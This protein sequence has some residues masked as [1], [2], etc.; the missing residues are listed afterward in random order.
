MKRITI[1]LSDQ[2][3]VRLMPALIAANAVFVVT[4]LLRGLPRST[5]QPDPKP[6]P[7]PAKKKR[8]IQFKD[9]QGRTSN[10]VILQSV[11]DLGS[12][13]TARI[14]LLATSTGFHDYTFREAANRLVKSGQLRREGNTY[15]PLKDD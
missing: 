8:H 5:Q 11:R 7:A 15:L 6:L 4:P 9:D 1:E 13:D 3:A 10:E 2:D 14:K 12:V